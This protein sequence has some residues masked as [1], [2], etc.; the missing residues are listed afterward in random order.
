MVESNRRKIR[1]L[2]YG[3][4]PIGQAAARLAHKASSI[5]LVGG[6][7]I[8]PE[9]VGRDLGLACDL[10]EPL[11]V[12]VVEP[13]GFSDESRLPDV[14]IHATGSRLED[15]YDQIANLAGSGVSVISTCEELLFPWYRNPERA[16]SLDRLAASTGAT[17]LG[18]GV[19]PGFVLDTLALA[20]TGVCHE[21]HR[22]EGI[23]IVDAA[24]R[25]L[26]L[27]RKIGAG[28]DPEEFRERARRQAIGHAGLIE[29][30]ALVAENLSLGREDGALDI[31]ETIE[32]VI[33]RRALQVHGIH[34]EPGQVAGIHQVARGSSGGKE[35]IRLDLQMYV[36]A[37]DPIDE[38]RIEG[39]PSLT[40][41]IPG[42]IAGDPA[43]AA[44]LVNAVPLLASV[45]PGLVTMADLPVPRR[46]V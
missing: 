12:D 9:I 23:R 35:R 10:V 26:P 24:T 29:S 1:V 41:R 2:C 27:V 36:G 16:E 32:P 46:T 28:I 13:P 19:N 21:I 45:R 31:D 17:V 34:V 44:M 30:L 38:I 14:A 7:D 39:T 18:T 33:A 37:T 43:T 4:G 3:L 42:G 25:R 40:V 11:G 5:D 8:D 20:F 22:I 6:V 15:V